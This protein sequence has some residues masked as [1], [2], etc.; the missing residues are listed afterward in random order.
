MLGKILACYDLVI[1][2]SDNLT[3]ICYN[4]AANVEKYY[5]SITLVKKSQEKVCNSGK[6]NHRSQNTNDKANTRVSTSYLREQVTDADY[7]FSFLDVS[8]SKEIAE[9]PKQS[10]SSAFFS[11]FSSPNVNNNDS[12]KWKTPK[13]RSPR[14]GDVKSEKKRE[15]KRSNLEKS[16]RRQSKDLFESQSSVDDEFRNVSMDWKL[17]PDEDIIRRVREKCFGRSDF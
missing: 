5:E 15:E 6:A 12:Y 2:K 14:Y 13:T 11:Y 17:T 7:T 16:R 1:K 8:F 3:Y 9:E 4:C 10:N